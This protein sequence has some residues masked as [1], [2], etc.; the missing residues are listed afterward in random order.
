MSY[1]AVLL[2][3]KAI[4]Q[5][6]TVYFTKSDKDFHTTLKST[7]QLHIIAHLYMHSKTKIPLKYVLKRVMNTCV[8]TLRA[9]KPLNSSV[10]GILPASRVLQTH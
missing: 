2:G 3:E 8:G 6:E 9:G 5:K 7:S 1:Y 4:T 10:V